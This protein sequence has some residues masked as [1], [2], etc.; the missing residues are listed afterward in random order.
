MACHILSKLFHKDIARL[1]P[2]DI[3]AL[4]MYRFDTYNAEFV[5]SGEPHQTYTIINDYIFKRITSE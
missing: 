5:T 2:L 3:F 4:Q 1:D